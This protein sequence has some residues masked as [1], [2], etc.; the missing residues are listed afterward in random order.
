M[1]DTSGQKRA[2]LQ[3]LPVVLRYVLILVVIGAVSLFF[4]KEI[5]FKYNFEKGK[6]WNYE[7]LVAPFD[8]PILKTEAELSAEIAQLDGE[9][10]PCYV[11]DGEIAG[12]QLRE[13]DRLFTTQLAKWQK[14]GQFDDVARK[15]D[16]YASYGRQFLTRI[17]DRGVVAMSEEH[18]NEDKD[19]VVQVFRGNK[20]QNQTLENLYPAAAAKAEVIDSLPYSG[21]AEPEFLLPILDF[22][23]VENVV[24]DDSLTSRL[25]AQ[26]LS[27]VTTSRG[28]VAAGEPIVYRGAPVTEDIYQKLVSFKAQYE[29]QVIE[30]KSFFGVFLGYLL[31]VTLVIGVFTFYLK[32][33]ATQIF[34]K[35]NALSFIFSLLLIFCYLSFLVQQTS[36]E[37]SPYLIPFAIV[38]ILVRVFFNARVAFFNHIVIILLASLI[39]K[40]G[41]EFIV[42]QF[43]AGAV[44]MLSNLDTRVWSRFFVGI[45]SIFFAY[46]LGYI[47]LSLIQEGSLHHVQWEVAGW[48][49]LNVFLTL[50]A[51]PL[52]PLLEK[53]FGFTS[54][55]TLMELSDLNR[56][57]LQ[58]LATEAPGTFQHSLQVGNLAEAAA[59]KIGADPLLVKVAALYHDIGK[60]KNPAYFIENQGG[61][62]SKHEQ[63]DPLESAKIIID[64][65]TYGVELAKKHRLP[66]K[67][68]DFIRTHHGTTLVAYF[69]RMYQN[70]FPDQV[71]EEN[72]FRYPGP[73]PTSREESLLMM[74]DSIEAAAKS[75]KDP[76]EQDLMDLVDK[77]VGGKMTQGQL[78]ESKLSFREFKTSVQEFKKIMKSIYHVRIKYPDEKPPK[79]LI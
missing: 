37:W 30:D 65:V 71:F 14:E 59:R 76:T 50:L 45:S 53:L 58:R 62:T 46:I 2:W 52:T 7:D 51:Y 44:V 23:V 75:L 29:A 15:P 74:A 4:P 42:I 12:R 36:G 63:L 19:F 9:F 77:I 13:F 73:K 1:T 57:L 31:L 16:S 20:K 55:I 8:F 79:E 69:F 26:V 43:I 27:G 5:T 21:L 40:Q 28:M 11:M 47:G 34:E 10:P 78:D 70:Q 39:A 3:Q 38:P 66:K 35:L 48:I 41:Y 68:V 49:G 32:K 72:L 6:S 60:L 17:F 64:H 67:L 25:K 33:D 24:F 56:P 22:L 61:Q 18:K 54:Y